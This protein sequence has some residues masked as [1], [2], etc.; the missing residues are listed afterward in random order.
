LLLLF[1]SGME[2]RSSF[3]GGER[4]VA[5]LITLFGTALPFGAGLAF[6]RLHEPSDLM[7]TAQNSTALLLVFAIA[8]AVTSIPVISRIMFDLGILETPFARIVLSAA[9]LEDV[10]LY[11][12]LAIAIGMVDGHVEQ[13]GIAK[14][15]ALD[16]SAEWANAYH[17]A[18]TL[19]FFGLFLVV[20]RPLFH[21]VANRQMTFVHRS[22]PIASLIVFMLV[23]TALA[24]FAGI[25]AM[26][27]AFVAGMVAGTSSE[28]APSG[29]EAGRR[30]SDRPRE[31]IKSFSFA[32]F[33]PVYFAIVGVRL[34]LVHAFDPMFFATFLTYACIAKLGSVYLGA[35]IAGE[36]R[37]GAR[38]LAVAMNARGGPGIVLA[39]VAYDSHIINQAFYVSLV[40]LAIVTSLLAGSWLEA[41]VRSGRPIR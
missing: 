21:W 37:H 15:L 31:A 28:N 34:D 22:T 9:V 24:V 13:F 29:P 5:F 14:M 30:A 19:A 18:I 10:I 40:M 39:S 41:V 26:F 23:V 2:I 11:V 12:V 20:G 35:S 17:V 33:V 4:K 27:G 38:N 8:I 6:L 7:G 1:C 25:P 32:F 36:S 3:Q 16:V